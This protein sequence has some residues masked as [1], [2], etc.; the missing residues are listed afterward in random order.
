MPLIWTFLVRS[1]LH[2][3]LFVLARLFA[4]RPSTVVFRFTSATPRSLPPTFA[5]C[6]PYQTTT[7][8]SST[9][10]VLALSAS[11]FADIYVRKTIPLWHCTVEEADLS[12]YAPNTGHF[13]SRYEQ[14]C[15]R[16]AVYCILAGGQHRS[17]ARCVRPRH[18]SH[19]CGQLPTAGMHFL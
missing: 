9:L 15:W 11:A 8:F 13:P 1:P 7:M 10:V 12:I 4:Q 18:S 14:L 19:L 16:P 2:P 5:S 3:E 17:S 6:R